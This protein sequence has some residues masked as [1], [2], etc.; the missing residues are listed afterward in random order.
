[1]EAM[2]PVV[3]FDALRVKIRQ[4]GVVRNKAV[5]LV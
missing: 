3:F 4:D 2:Y 5:Y 1:L